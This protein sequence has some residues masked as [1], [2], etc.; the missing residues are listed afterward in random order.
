M[1]ALPA[2]PQAPTIYGP[3]L[4]ALNRAADDGQWLCHVIRDTA[5]LVALGDARDPRHTVVRRLLETEAGPLVIPAPVTAEIDYLV[6]QR[7]GPGAGR[8][9]LEDL[10]EGRFRVEGLTQEEHRLALPLHDRYA[11]LDLGL[12]DLAVVVLAHRYRTRRLLPSTSGTFAVLRPWMAAP[13]CFS[14]ATCRSCYA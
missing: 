13:S 9:F 14:R 12:A 8:R 2:S 1:P 10:A 4:A 5:P 7:G 3:W 11:A 6:R